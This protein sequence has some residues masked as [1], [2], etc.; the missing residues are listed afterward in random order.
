MRR[1]IS[2][3][4]TTRRSGLIRPRQL[5]V[6]TSRTAGTRCWVVPLY[7][8]IQDSELEEAVDSLGVESLI[9]LRN[10][11]SLSFVHLDVP[12]Q[13]RTFSIKAGPV[14]ETR[15][16]IGTELSLVAHDELEVTSPAESSGTTFQRYWTEQTVGLGSARLN[17]AT[18]KVTPLGVC[19]CSEPRQPGA[20]HDRVPLPISID[21]P[22]SLNPQFDPDGAR[23]AILPTAWNKDRLA[24][25]GEFLGAVAL[26]AFER[27]PSTAWMHVPLKSEGIEASDW[28]REQFAEAIT[29]ACHARL[30]A[31]LHL[32][33]DAGRVAL[34]Q[35]VYESED[36]GALVT[37]SDLEL[38]AEGYSA[39]L[40]TCRD[41]FARW[42]EVLNELGKSRCLGPADALELFGHLPQIEGREPLWFVGMAALAIKYGL[43]DA[44]SQRDSLL[45][46][47]GQI[48]ACPARSGPR[49]LVRND[50]PQNLARRLGLALPLHGAYLA[51][52]IE[53]K[54]VAVKLSEVKALRDSCDQPIGAL[55]LLARSEE[56]TETPVRLADDDLLAVR[57][58][59]AH[60]ARDEQ[61]DMG[62]RSTLRAVANGSD[63]GSTA[64]KRSSRR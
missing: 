64:T 13:G 36:V 11:R 29:G 47:S 53:A 17:K 20:L 55:R 63:F 61:R 50:N 43:W 46:A 1:S 8:E 35:I 15:L 33:T 9:F 49:V 18:G 37:P 32:P 60:L 12:E 52:T 58:A 39:I 30:I 57:D 45:L 44:F 22:I 28:V 3:C 56:P 6:G 24:D 4:L 25:L 62:A 7:P 34:P 59:W 23:S 16:R 19:I 54:N 27:D 51:E 31:E 5:L 38:L 41:Q 10:I 42:R 40:L 2:P 48:V 14:R 21:A 26:E